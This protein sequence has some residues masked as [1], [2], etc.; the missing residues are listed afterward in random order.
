MKPAYDFESQAN[1]SLCGPFFCLLAAERITAPRS[2]LRSATATD[3]FMHGSPEP[4]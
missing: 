2:K 4:A 3:Q 1:P